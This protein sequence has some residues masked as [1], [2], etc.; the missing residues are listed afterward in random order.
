MYL[1][2]D[3]CLVLYLVTLHWQCIVN[4]NLRS[5]DTSYIGVPVSICLSP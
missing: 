5:L 3:L 4:N 2:V 1:Y